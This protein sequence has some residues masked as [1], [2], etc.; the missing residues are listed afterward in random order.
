M[1]RPAKNVRFSCPLDCFDVCGLVATVVDKRVVK[2]RGDRDHPL[3]RGVCCIKGLKLLERLYHPQRLTSPLKRAG[4]E[5]VPVSWPEALD[6]IVSK[7][8]QTIGEFGSS[9]ILN[10]AGGGHGGL[11]KKV[12]EIF[13]NYLGGVTVP[14]GSLCW[15]AGIAAQRYDF[16]EVRGHHPA[17]LANSKLIILWG[18][19]PTDT[20]RHLVPY[21]QAARKSGATIVLIDP[22]RSASAELADHHL[23]VRPA[24]DGALALG[25]AHAIITSGRYDTEYIKKRVYGFERFRQTIQPCTL[26]WTAEVT[27]ISQETVTWLA[28]LYAEKK[29]ASIIIGYGL[30]RYGNGGNTVRSIDALGAITGNIG[31]SGG[32]INYANW[33]FPDYIGGEFKNSQAQARNRRTFS[34]ARLA[35]YLETEDS[36]P[37][38]C[39]F[40]SKANPL[41]QGPDINRTTAAFTAIDFKVVIDLFMT[42]TARHADLILP[43]TSVLEEE[44]I[45]FSSMFS[46]YV[47]YSGRAVSPPAGVMGEYEIYRELSDRLGL[48]E[49]PRYERRKFLEEAIRPLTETCGVA[50]E[51]LKRAPFFLP[52]RA[53]PWQDGQ[54]ATPSGKFELYSEHALT[55]G[56]SPVATYVAAAAGNPEYPLRLLTPHRR[57]SMHSQHF[58]FIDDMPEAMVSPETLRA[59]RLTDGARAKVFSDQGSLLVKIRCDS[60]AAADAVTIEQGW[61]NKS[62]SVNVLTADRISEMGEQAAYYDCFVSVAPAAENLK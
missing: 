9:A 54:F 13:F 21:I 23:A 50:L 10:Y 61:W 18:R 33:F 24:T 2:I 56:C 55:D 34:I 60:G 22:R 52:D 48:S 46:P 7:L 37:I 49:Y 26:Q 47:N 38:R 5:W 57:D 28:Q 32:G 12:D 1:T 3:T 62:G 35:E 44:D 30:Q 42:D 11:A 53:V 4:R 40:V 45:I 16:G 29:P 14:R 59:F 15:G 19:N 6:E 25:L 31:V 58:A 41:V 36:P 43:C 39:I 17:D 51:D 27:G 8:S 20:N